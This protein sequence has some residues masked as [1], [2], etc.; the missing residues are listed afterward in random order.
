[1]QYLADQ[2][3]F[4]FAFFDEA[5]LIDWLVGGDFG[6]VDRDSIGGDELAGFALAAGEAGGDEDVNES[7]AGFGGR[8]ALGEKF[9]VG[10]VEIFD[11]TVAE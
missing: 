5:E 7:L 3:E 10:S 4:V 9:D 1:M 2:C 6:A 8:E 11:F